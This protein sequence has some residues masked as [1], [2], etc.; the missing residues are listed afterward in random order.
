[1]E[2]NF[3]TAG[4]LASVVDIL[5]LSGVIMTLVIKIRRLGKP[6][7]SIVYR[8]RAILSVLMPDHG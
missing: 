4:V 1:M 5:I 6:G 7:S 3:A 8:M 2:I